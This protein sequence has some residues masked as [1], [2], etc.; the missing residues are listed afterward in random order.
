MP[1]L[2]VITGP[3]GVGK[4]TISLKLAEIELVKET[5]KEM[6]VLLLDDV[7]SELDS[8]RQNLLLNQ[9]KDIQTIITCTGVED[10]IKNR[11][12]INKIFHVENAKVSI[13]ES[14]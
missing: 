13:K 6:P 7:L 8:V 10:F 9:I 4:S 5:V 1:N 11:F 3:A 12:R 2:Y 14:L